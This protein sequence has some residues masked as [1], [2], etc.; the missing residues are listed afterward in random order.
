VANFNSLITKKHTCETFFNVIPH[1]SLTNCAHLGQ[2]SL[3][4]PDPEI[5]YI[6]IQRGIDK[7][8]HG[9]G[10]HP[11]GSIFIDLLK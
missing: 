5:V 9:V 8:G 2:R 10:H 4:F 7:D 11:N 6:R 3:L 1:K